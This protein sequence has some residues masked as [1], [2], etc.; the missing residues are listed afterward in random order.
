MNRGAW[1]AIVQRVTKS[2]TKHTHWEAAGIKNLLVFF[3]AF[4]YSP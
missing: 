4:E 2:W 1:Q 3:S